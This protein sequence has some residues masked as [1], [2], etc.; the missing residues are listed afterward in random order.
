M[1]G[2]P[3]HEESQRIDYYTLNIFHK[4]RERLPVLLCAGDILRAHRVIPEQWNGSLHLTSFN[5]STFTVLRPRTHNLRS[6]GMS[7]ESLQD[8]N[9]DGC[10]KTPLIMWRVNELWMKGQEMF[11]NYPTVDARFRFTIADMNTQRTNEIGQNKKRNDTKYGDLTLMIVDIIPYPVDKCSPLSPK[12]YLRVWD[13]T[14]IPISDQMPFGLNRRYDNQEEPSAVAISSLAAIIN[15]IN[16]N[17]GSQSNESMVDDTSRSSASTSRLNPPISFCGRVTNVVIWEQDHWNLIKQAAEFIN[18]GKF[19]RLRNVREGNLYCP[20]TDRKGSRCLNV[21]SSALLTPLPYFTFEIAAILKYHNQRIQQG[22]PY[23][24]RSA[25]LPMS[26]PEEISN[27]CDIIDLQPYLEEQQQLG[28]SKNYCNLIECLVEEAPATFPVRF[29]VFDVHSLSIEL[30]SETTGSNVVLQVRDL[31]FE[32]SVIIPRREMLDLY[33]DELNMDLDKDH[34]DS[35]KVILKAL[36]YKSFESTI[37]SV[38]MNDTKYFV[39][40]DQLVLL[41]NQ[42]DITR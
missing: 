15:K 33:L 24:P 6:F 35:L 28:T 42:R 2:K 21:D 34:Q 29:Q 36:Q 41:P 17:G 18:V 13:G 11:S 10:R 40:N 23:N 14:G 38:M 12:G 22:D 31:T 32:L 19:I 25:C 3:T 30:N 37:H 20:D 16:S 27:Q 1:A 5:W 9:I 39:L 4:S 8:W 7:T 26:I